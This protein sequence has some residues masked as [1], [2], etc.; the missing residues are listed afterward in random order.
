MR[1][2][3]SMTIENVLRLPM[4]YSECSFN[5]AMFQLE[6]EGVDIKAV[7]PRRIKGFDYDYVYAVMNNEKVHFIYD[8]RRGYLMMDDEEKY[9]DMYKDF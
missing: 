8:E 3:L 7:L 5:E 1:K 2:F 9:T 6:Y 4:V